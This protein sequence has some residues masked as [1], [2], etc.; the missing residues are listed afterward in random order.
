MLQDIFSG[1]YSRHLSSAMQGA[2][3]GR[4][5]LKA[6]TIKLAKILGSPIRNSLA[7]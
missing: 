7:I 1:I 4:L 2:T 3:K 5:P 6:V